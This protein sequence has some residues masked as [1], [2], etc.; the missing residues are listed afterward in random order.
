M[1]L[2]HIT[3]VLLEECDHCLKRHI[4]MREEDRSP[5]F[6]SEV[7]PHV[8]HI[9]ALVASWKELSGEWVNSYR[10]RHVRMPQIENAA[11]A[12]N[13]FVV[14]SF[15]KETGKKRFVQS[16]QSVKFTLETLLRA[17]RKEEEYES[18]KDPF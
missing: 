4:T 1:S 16:I 2:E 10:P 12:M 11:D 18:E 13:Q 17:M 8:D 6:Y 7:K 5:D 3:K 15:Y 9:H 14:Q